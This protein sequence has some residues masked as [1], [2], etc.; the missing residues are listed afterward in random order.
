MWKSTFLLLWLMIPMTAHA[1]QAPAPAPPSRDGAPIALPA[2]V[3]TPPDYLIGVDDVLAVMFWRE[4]DLSTDVQ[5]RPDGKITLPLLNDVQ[6][7]GLTPDQLREKI[8]DAA[9][10]FVEDPSVTVIVKAM[11][12]RKVYITGQVLKPGQYLLGVPTTVMQLIAMAGGLHEYADKGNIVILRTEG[13]QQVAHRF[14]YDDIMKRKNL[15]Q[16]IGLRPGD[17]V[18]V[19]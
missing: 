12:S 11:N 5:V 19:P 6:A 1:Q 16:N 7:A 4:A 18:I 17:T 10:R 8:T 15:K 2:G 14:N 9:K 3:V 13:G